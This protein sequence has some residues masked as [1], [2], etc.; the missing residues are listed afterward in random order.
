MTVDPICASGVVLLRGT[1][2][3]EPEVLL[4]H[5]PRYDDWSIPKGKD[6]PGEAP[7]E[8]AIREL[9]EETGYHATLGERLNDQEY[10]VR[11]RPKVVRYFVGRPVRFDGMPDQDEVDEMEWLPLSKAKDRLTYSRDQKLL[12]DDRVAKTVRVGWVHLI[13]HAHAGSR[14]KWK[15][16]DKVR[17]LT[18]KGR[19]QAASIA[20]RLAALGVDVIQSSPYVRCLETVKPLAEA[21]GVDVFESTHLAE[22]ANVEAT[23]ELIASASGVRIA[24]CSHGDVIPDIVESLR[25]QGMKLKSANGRL[26]FAKGSTWEILIEAGEPK[27][28]RYIPAPT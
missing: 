25:D 21:S 9:Y 7:G 2:A 28:A 11:G 3:G 19:R 1:L 20:E 13:R 10:E 5:R 23:L 22:G 18:D 14:S 6:D 12:A 26:Q 15:G 27:T 16:N 17:P 24:L 8:A 4:I